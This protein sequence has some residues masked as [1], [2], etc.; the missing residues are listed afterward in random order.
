MEL[1]NLLNYDNAARW[2]SI[3]LLFGAFHARAEKIIQKLKRRNQMD[4]IKIL[5]R[6]QRRKENKPNVNSLA[7]FMV[8][9]PLPIYYFPL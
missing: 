7:K 5:R 6:R 8:T 1:Y 3:T 2:E 9:S 4:S